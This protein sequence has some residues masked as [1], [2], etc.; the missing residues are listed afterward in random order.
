M[1]F[2]SLFCKPVVINRRLTVRAQHGGDIVQSKRRR[3][4]KCDQ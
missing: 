1:Q 4:T 3:L 2:V